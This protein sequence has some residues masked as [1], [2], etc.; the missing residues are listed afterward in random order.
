[1]RVIRQ[2]SFGLLA[3]IVAAC[4]FA[5]DAGQ[6][7]GLVTEVKG[8]VTSGVA[9]GPEKSLQMLQDLYSG[10]SIELAKGAKAAV[11]WCGTIGKDGAILSKHGE[12]TLSGPGRFK[13]T[14]QGIQD[15]S[16]GKMLPIREADSA[17][18]GMRPQEGKARTQAGATMRSVGD[19]GDMQPADATVPASEAAFAWKP[20][21]HRGMWRLRLMNDAGDTI[22]VQELPEARLSLP[23]TVRLEPAATYRWEVGWTD[24]NGQ[25]RF[26]SARFT[27][28]AAP[29]EQA[30]RRLKPQASAAPSERILFGLWLQDRGAHH[31]AAEYLELSSADK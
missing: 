5:G 11:F 7:L 27:T 25:S 26:M 24:R 6:A 31:L 28:L 13:I 3:W 19:D 12:Y 30:Y 29:E 1:M 17:Y 22:H 14:P 15:M 21:P 23:G 2:I 10:S 20:R 18:A 16:T 9:G 8:N 4:A